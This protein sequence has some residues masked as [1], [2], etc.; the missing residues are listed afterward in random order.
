MNKHISLIYTALA[1]SILL[2]AGCKDP[3]SPEPETND[4]DV[5]LNVNGKTVFTY[6]QMGCQASYD[7][8]TA[9]FC[10]FTDGMSD[11]FTVSCGTMPTEVEQSASAY[12]EWTTADD[13]KSKKC[14]LIVE[15]VDEVTGKIVLKN[16][17][18]KIRAVVF[19]IR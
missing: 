12:I 6:D 19:E 13:T 3:V 5:T 1:A 11:Y 15:A 2:V 14:E 8:K 9:T 4:F 18:E 16:D 7:E 17:A 10:A